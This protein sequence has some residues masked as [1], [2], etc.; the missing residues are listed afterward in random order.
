[1]NPRCNV[2]GGSRRGS[3]AF[4]AIKGVAELAE[5]RASNG[6]LTSQLVNATAMKLSMSVV[7]TSSTPKRARKRPGPT[8]QSPP[9]KDAVA[10]AT[11]I[12][13]NDGH[14]GAAKPMTA[15]TMPP[16]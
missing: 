3:S 16:R 8:S 15:A 6:P 13:T 4:S 11:K 5:P 10:N 2:V 14:V 1:M 7:T 9:A 12:K